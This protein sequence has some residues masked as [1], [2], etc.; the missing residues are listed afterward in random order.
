MFMYKGSASGISLTSED[1]LAAF[2]R[3]YSRRGLP[4]NMYSDNGKTFV[5]AK[6]EL[7]RDYETIKERLEPEIA[8]IMLNQSVQWSFIPPHAPHWGG[9]WEAGV[10]SM[11]H[12]LR[13]MCG[14]SVH[15]FQEYSTMLA[16]IEACLNSRP[17][18]PVS[19][20]PSDLS[21]LTP[22][23]FL[24]GDNLLALQDQVSLIYMSVDLV[25][26]SRYLRRLIIL[27]GVGKQNIYRNCST[28]ISGCGRA[29]M[30]KSVI[31][32]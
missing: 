8:D 18:C 24:I 27:K 28:E 21:V 25:N 23:H 10:K 17:L 29:K 15:T 26:G 9:L 12:H 6:N 5:G 32:C 19:N 3:F 30:C 7:K 2:K 1:F 20:D 22:A 4:A 16:E 31:W 13:R 11:K 14:E